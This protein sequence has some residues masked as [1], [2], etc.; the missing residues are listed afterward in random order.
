[1]GV[2]G[3]R[4]HRAAAVHR[5]D[6]GGYRRPEAHQHLTASRG[7]SRGVGTGS[8]WTRA[9][10]LP[11]LA[12]LATS[13]RRIGGRAALVR[14]TDLSARHIVPDSRRR[15]GPLANPE[16]RIPNHQS[17]IPNPESRTVRAGKPPAS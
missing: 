8:T 12:F 14:A 1:A 7:A 3:A 4:D 13:I 2:Q 10:G 11:T 15:P 16:S 5:P 9:S 17:R 6:R